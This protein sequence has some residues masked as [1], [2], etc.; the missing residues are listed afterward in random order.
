MV[1]SYR[2]WRVEIF[3]KSCRQAKG[4]FMRQEQALLVDHQQ[5]D[6]CPSRLSHIVHPSRTPA[7]DISP[8][9]CSLRFTVLALPTYFVVSGA[10]PSRV[11]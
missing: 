4:D 5:P 8:H 7:Y 9:V 3:V 2:Y 11:E 6:P 10:F 1:L